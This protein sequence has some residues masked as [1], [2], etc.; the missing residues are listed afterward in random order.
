MQKTRSTFPFYELHND[1][2]QAPERTMKGALK[3]HSEIGDQPKNNNTSAKHSCSVADCQEGFWM[4]AV[5]RLYGLANYPD[6]I[7]PGFSAFQ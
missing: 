4:A 2:T 7:V 1:G 3:S 5:F 6:R